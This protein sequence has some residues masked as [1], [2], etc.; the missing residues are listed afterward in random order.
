MRTVLL[1]GPSFL[2]HALLR[3]SYLQKD[4]F[5]VFGL[6]VSTALIFILV[7][8]LIAAFLCWWGFSFKPSDE[9]DTKKTGGSKS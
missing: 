7:P 4:G 5:M 8:L 9:I 3:C 2:L 6:P 1:L